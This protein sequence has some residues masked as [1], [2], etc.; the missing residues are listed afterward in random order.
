MDA[1]RGNTET[2]R[3]SKT[4]NRR[5]N[6]QDFIIFRNRGY[7]RNQRTKMHQINNSGYLNE[8][9][10]AEGVTLARTCE[11]VKETRGGAVVRE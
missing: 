11:Y 5:A 2:A 4:F 6:K 7:F 8:R 9:K 3:I 10:I 1:G